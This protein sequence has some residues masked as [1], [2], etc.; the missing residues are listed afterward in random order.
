MQVGTELYCAP[1]IIM[2]ERYNESVDTFS[3]ALVLL[4]LAVG[5]IG[6]IRNQ[7]RKKHS[8]VKYAF[9]GRPNIPW[10]LRESAPK[11]ADLIDEMWDA[12]FRR[13]PAFSAIVPR[14]AEC[15]SMNGFALT[16]DEQFAA[17]LAALM[18]FLGSSGQLENMF[19]DRDTF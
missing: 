9:G 14:L 3:F 11:L 17:P 7:S 8:R 16:A 12:D 15:T 13:R 19:S 18:Y 2:R 5:D 10:R 6:Y 1:E 4:C